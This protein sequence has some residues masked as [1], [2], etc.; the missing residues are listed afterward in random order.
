MFVVLLKLAVKE[1]LPS[2]CFE[3]AYEEETLKIAGLWGLWCYHER[4]HVPNCTCEERIRAVYAAAKE[5]VPKVFEDLFVRPPAREERPWPSFAHFMTTE[6]QL[7]DV[8]EKNVKSLP[9][10]LEFAFIDDVKFQ[11]KNHF[12]IAEAVLN[13][14]DYRGTAV[15]GNFTLI[16]CPAARLPTNVGKEQQEEAGIVE[17]PRPSTSPAA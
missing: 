8:L 17:E 13:Y 6:R 2:D 1:L 14:N 11:C 7:V 4:I 9:E 3:D 15:S 16:I 10:S 12:T 5:E